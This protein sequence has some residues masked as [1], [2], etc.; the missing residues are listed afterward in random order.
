MSD[1]QNWTDSE[2]VMLNN[3]LIKMKEA[4][5]AKTFP[6]IMFL[7]S[8]AITIKEPIIGGILIVASYLGFKH[9]ADK[10][11]TAEQEIERLL[12]SKGQKRED[13]F[14]PLY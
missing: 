2:K 7:L 13:F 5:K 10:A 8:G 1:F 6:V 11:I 14:P 3:S 9:F 12:K 4:E